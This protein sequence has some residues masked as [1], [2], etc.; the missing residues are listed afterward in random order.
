MVSLQP[1]AADELQAAAFWRQVAEPHCPHPETSLRGTS[2]LPMNA[3]QAIQDG[4]PVMDVFAVV[5]AQSLQHWF[6]E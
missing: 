6:L 4:C 5:M 1:G 2:R 3:C